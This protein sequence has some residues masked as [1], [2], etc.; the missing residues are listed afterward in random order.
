MSL[1]HV[2][3]IVAGV[4]PSGFTLTPSSARSLSKGHYHQVAAL[5]RNNAG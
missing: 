4:I 5:E 3:F 2:H 1:P